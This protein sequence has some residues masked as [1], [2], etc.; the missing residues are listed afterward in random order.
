[1]EIQFLDEHTKV[2]AYAISELKGKSLLQISKGMEEWRRKCIT[3]DAATNKALFL[4]RCEDLLGKR[5]FR[6]IK[7]SM[8]D[9]HYE[10]VSCFFYIKND[11]PRFYSENTKVGIWAIQHLNGRKTW[12]NYAK[13]LNVGESTRI[14]YHPA[15]CLTLSVKR[16]PDKNGQRRFIFIRD[17]DGLERTS[18]FFTIEQL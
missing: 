13:A 11:R 10:W 2:A 16:Y 1:M 7:K 9:D 17:V 4:E 12:W 15:E 18:S 8:G 5:C 3:V 6:F 14:F